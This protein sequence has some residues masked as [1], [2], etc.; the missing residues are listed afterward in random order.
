MTGLVCNG[1]AIRALA[2]GST[3]HARELLEI[4]LTEGIGLAVPAA[5]YAAAWVWSTPPAR[6]LLD[7]FLEL[8]AVTVDP[9]DAATARAVGVVLARSGGWAA[10]DVG[11]VVVSAR[12]RG[13]PVLAVDSGP[14]L[15]VAP[16]VAVET[17]P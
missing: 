16:D 15:A 4:A 17:L 13:W 14:L 8:S 1:G 5:A 3:V 10:L 2:V 12:A 6:M 7:D 11:Q 9:L